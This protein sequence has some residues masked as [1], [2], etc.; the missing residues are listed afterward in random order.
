MG[1]GVGAMLTSSVNV[2]QS[3]SPSALS[4]LMLLVIRLI[5]LLLALLLPAPQTAVPAPA[6]EHAG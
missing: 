4:A 3:A 6:K 5:G 1:I 2:V